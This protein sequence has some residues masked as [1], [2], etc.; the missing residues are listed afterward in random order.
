MEHENRSKT[1]SPTNQTADD[2]V[3]APHITVTEEND[4]FVHVG[5]VEDEG[6]A[7][8][9]ETTNEDQRTVEMKP[10]EEEEKQLSLSNGGQ[11][12]D[13]ELRTPSPPPLT[14]DHSL[15]HNQL[16]HKCKHILHVS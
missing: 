2:H 15:K 12:A 13:E 8:Q 7:R 16:T 4:A 10:E 9:E 5:E 6:K 11:H 3:E 14:T 1:S